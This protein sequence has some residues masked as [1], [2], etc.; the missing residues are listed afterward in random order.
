MATKNVF[1]V[2][3]LRRADQKF[4][5]YIGKG[6]GSRAHQHTKETNLR[7]D[8]S[9]KASIIKS[10]KAAGVEVL[11]EYLAV[12]LSEKRAFDTEES[13]IAAYGRRDQGTG[14]LAN[15]T[16]GREGTSGFKNTE[17]SRALMREKATERQGR[18]EVRSGIAESLRGR[19]RS[20][21][22]ID[23]WRVSMG[24]RIG[25]A[26]P[27]K[28]AVKDHMSP[29]GRANQKA[30]ASRP[31]SEST[32]IKLKEA[33]AGSKAY[34]AK[35]TDAQVRKIRRMH[36]SGKFSITELAARHD[37]SLAGMSRIVN[38]ASYKNVE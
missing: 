37:M 35:L 3:Q 26:K 22:S 33:C 6:K 24:D 36:A 8:K 29:E 12:G 4:P 30:A 23:K 5:F 28:A 34:N 38:R 11:V 20:Q 2:Y 31:P 19:K 25:T 9:F 17:D 1:Y 32:L 18:L 16:D 7:R 13:L 10:A 21:E 14:C 15:L 27:I